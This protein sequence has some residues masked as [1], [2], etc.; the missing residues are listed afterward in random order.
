MLIP[1]ARTLLVLSLL[2]FPQGAQSDIELKLPGPPAQKLMLGTW[3]IRVQYEPTKDLPKGDVGIGE[4]KWYPGPGGLSLVEEYH[5][6]NSKGEISGLG[7]AW[8]DDQAAGIRVLWCESTNPLGCNLPGI[9]KWEGDR[10]VLDADQ[11][12]AGKK[13]KFREVFSDITAK[14]FKQTLS[15]GETEAQLKPFV[16]IWATRK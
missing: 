11:E 9:A 10:L 6:N 5:E 3:S 4:E 12:I 8:W 1:A 15:L 16:T 2:A 7:V 13:F 14:S